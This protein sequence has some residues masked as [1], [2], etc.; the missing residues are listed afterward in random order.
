MRWA[1][2]SIHAAAVEID[3]DGR[4][5]LNGSNWIPLGAPINPPEKMVGREAAEAWR[6]GRVEEW[7]GA[8]HGR[9]T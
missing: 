4:Y 9:T 5:T 6:R 8:A 3:N 7:K 1:V 2:H